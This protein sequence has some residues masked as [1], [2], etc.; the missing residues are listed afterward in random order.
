MA[1]VQ[2]TD[3]MLGR[4][5]TCYNNVGNRIFRKLI[6]E[7]VI[8]YRN[9]ARRSEKGALVKLLVSKL[10]AKGCRFFHRSST[11][12]WVEASPEI[13]EKKVGHG[14]RDARL[15]AGRS[16]PKNFRPAMTEQKHADADHVKPVSAGE[17]KTSH[18]TALSP[19]C[20]DPQYDGHPTKVQKSLNHMKR[21]WEQQLLDEDE[22]SFLNESIE[23]A[24]LLQECPLLDGGREEQELSFLE[25]EIEG[26]FEHRDGGGDINK[27]TEPHD[28]RFA[29]SLNCV[30]EETLDFLEQSSG[31][32]VDTPATPDASPSAAATRDVHIVVDAVDTVLNMYSFAYEVCTGDRSSD[33]PYEQS[34]CA[35]DDAQ[36]LCRWFSNLS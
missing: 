2:P 8:F 19:A 21:E 25:F 15:E 36:S 26:D 29:S 24:S 4:G 7:N 11:G 23:V 18:K 33:Y 30:I 14:L 5:P 9:Q 17:A 20:A 12:V 6:K 32:I 27:I 28:A 10:Q 3:I 35:V 16:L 1:C 13:A 31:D 34:G 22:P